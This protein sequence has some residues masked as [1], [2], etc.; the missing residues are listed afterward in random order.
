MRKSWT[1][2]DSLME[3]SYRFCVTSWWHTFRHPFG[4]IDDDIAPLVFPFLLVYAFLFRMMS[5][6]DVL[7]W[8]QTKDSSSVFFR[9]PKG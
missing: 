1:P 2:G 3:T 5:N 7:K 9:F 4:D 8:L 6:L